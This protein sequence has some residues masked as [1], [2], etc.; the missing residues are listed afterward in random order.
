MGYPI[1]VTIVAFGTLLGIEHSPP[2][3]VETIVSDRGR[4]YSDQSFAFETRLIFVP[5]A[6][7][8]SSPSIRSI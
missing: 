7:S 2:R 8:Q 4:L 5:W 3:S 1:L 6:F